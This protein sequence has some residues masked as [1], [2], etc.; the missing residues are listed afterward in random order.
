MSY[1]VH[2]LT[3]GNVPGC[4][5]RKPLGLFPLVADVAHDGDDA[6][7]GVWAAEGLESGHE[8]GDILEKFALFLVG[9]AVEEVG[10]LGEGVAGEGAAGKGA[11]W[12]DVATELKS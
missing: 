3:H 7:D 1:I 4:A 10:E 11:A 8:F 5:D 6:L 9:L 12:D 2:S